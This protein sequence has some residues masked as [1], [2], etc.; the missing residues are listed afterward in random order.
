MQG[1]LEV[2]KVQF[3]Q[4]VACIHRELSL[5][6]ASPAVRQQVQSFYEA[7]W[8]GRGCFEIMRLD[9]V[10][11][12]CLAA[13]VALGSVDFFFETVPALSACS[14]AQRSQLALG[15]RSYFLPTGS[16][17]ADIGDVMSEVIFILDGQV[18]AIDHTGKVCAAFVLRVVHANAHPRL[19]S[20]IT[21]AIRCGASRGSVRA[22]LLPSPAFS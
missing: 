3:E 13:E 14:R 7:L 17:I 18:V 16:I 5:R 15:A 10:L 9:D 8:L 20:C 11:P 1:N 4:R 22:S 2:R 6:K 12:P 19:R 21:R